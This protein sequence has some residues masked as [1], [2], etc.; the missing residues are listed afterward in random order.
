M[1]A[2]NLSDELA[3]GHTSFLCDTVSLPGLNIE[4]GLSV[5]FSVLIQV[6]SY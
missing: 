6:L 3:R 4:V 5:A 1:K 2:T